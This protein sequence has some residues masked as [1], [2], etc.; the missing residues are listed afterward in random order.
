MKFVDLHAQ[1]Q[2]IRSNIEERIG[3]VLDHGQYV[4]GPEIGD[5]EEKLADFTGTRYALACSSGTDA[6]LMALMAYGVGPGD[7]IF[8]TPFTFVATAE[9]VALLG[10]T[11]VFVDIDP[12]TFNL[13]PERLQE[14]VHSVAEEGLAPFCDETGREGKLTPRGI[15]GVDLF[16]IPADYDRIGAVAKSYGLFVVEDAAQ[17]FGAVQNGKM[18]CNL[19]HIG[20][21]SFFPSKPLAGYGDG[22]M[23]FTQDEELFET[24]RSV[25]IHGM[26]AHQYENIRIGINGRLDTIQAA[27]LL[28]K[29]EIFPNEMNQRQE[30]ADRYHALLADIP[31]LV[32]PTVPAGTVSAWAQ[33]SVLAGN[34]AD[35]RKRRER[36]Q[37]ADIPTAVYY[38]M[39]LHLQS[40]FRKLGYRKGHFPVSEDAAER[41]FSLPMHPYLDEEQQRSI[42]EALRF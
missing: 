39:P 40:A 23:C 42:A 37:H 29:F 20:C 5:L 2:R 34:E 21:T 12:V 25:R 24:M 27:V 33:Y 15:I 36:L 22:G 8:T 14:A 41:I 31:G 13:N 6:L 7:A 30:A 32:P 1:Q 3:K 28:A 26:G 17:S 10:A 4:M 11:P 18:A 38:P 9:V 19:A 35:R 16:G